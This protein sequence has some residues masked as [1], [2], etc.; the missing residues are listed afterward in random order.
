M[1]PIAARQIP[2]AT[3]SLPLLLTF[4]AG[5][6]DTAG[7][8]ALQGLFTAHVTGNFITLG[9]SIALGISGALTKMLALPVFCMVVVLTRLVSQRLG[10]RGVPALRAL[11]GINTGLLVC[12]AG[13]MM[14]LAPGHGGD[15]WQAML[16]GLVLV[17]A[18]ATQNGLHRIHLPSVPPGTLMTGTTTQLMID[19]ADVLRGVPV[20]AGRTLRIRM[21][22]MATQIGVFAVG[23]IIAAMVFASFGNWCFAPAP[24]VALLGWSLLRAPRGI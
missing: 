1:S 21:R 17:A 19:L 2:A 5:Y 10:E 4:N 8:L 12:G 9:T 23:C 18:G 16:S 20:E 22:Q 14:F 3:S 11:L 15:D 24:L 13:L 6:I 7:F